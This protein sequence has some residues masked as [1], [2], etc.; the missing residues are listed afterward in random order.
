M[1]L[2]LMPT[3]ALLNDANPHLINFYRWLQ[4]GLAIELT[5]ENRERP[6]YQQRERFNALLT[7][8]HADDAEA[9]ALFY[10]LNRTGYNGLCRPNARAHPRPLTAPDTAAV[11][12]QRDVSQP[13]VGP[14]PHSEPSL[15]PLR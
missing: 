4:R 6:Y 7:E 2:G 11:G 9:A 8:G 12:V 13:S 10:Y 5:M 3:H 1:A 15:E 14:D